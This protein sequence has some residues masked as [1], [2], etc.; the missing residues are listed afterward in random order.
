MI[1]VIKRS[2]AVLI[3]AA[4]LIL[5][6]GFWAGQR[7]DSVPA[8]GSGSFNKTVIIDAGHGEPDGGCVA[9]DGTK[10]AGL[11]LKIA[12]KLAGILEQ[13][14]CK[15]IMTRTTDEGIYDKTAKN[16]TQ[17]KR[18]DMYRRRDIQASANADIFISIHINKFE[19]EKYYGAQVM[20]DTKNPE[21]KELAQALQLALREGLDPANKREIMAA[22]SDIFLLKNA[23]LPS[24][25][26]ECGFLS[27][28]DEL[29]LLKTDEYQNRIAWAVY[30]G[31][32]KY[33]ER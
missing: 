2:S 18:A 3:L 1:M 21:S 25:I 16:I 23:P 28:K 26:V 8:S 4:A 22:N 24:V 14:G 32:S 27:N 9:D 5:L 33:F 31:I 12:Q 15:V 7:F 20:Y 30:M 17:K 29:E 10:E 11:N 13:S 6:A 19:Q